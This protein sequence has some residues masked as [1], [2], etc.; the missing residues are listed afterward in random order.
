[1]TNSTNCVAHH[2]VFLV[3]L[4][5]LFSYIP[6]VVIR[7]Y[8]SNHVTSRVGL[9]KLETKICYYYYYYY[10]YYPDGQI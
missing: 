3:V 8:I 9:S 10:Y 6:F 4:P 5:I 2:H 7:L 1:M